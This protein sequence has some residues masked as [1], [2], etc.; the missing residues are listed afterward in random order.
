MY[1]KGETKSL[2]ND[3]SY[4]RAAKK[5]DY[6]NRKKNEKYFY[7]IYSVANIL[8]HLQCNNIC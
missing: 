3:D 1:R 5:S 7:I 6:R 4:R 2:I 8:Y